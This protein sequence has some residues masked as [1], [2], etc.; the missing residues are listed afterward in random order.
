MYQRVLTRPVCSQRDVHELTP[1]EPRPALRVRMRSTV[2]QAI[3]QDCLDA[4]TGAA[5]T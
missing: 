1:L 4:G 3:C 2:S 5:V